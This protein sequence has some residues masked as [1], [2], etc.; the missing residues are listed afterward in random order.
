[1]LN[2]FID[3]IETSDEACLLAVLPENESMAVAITAAVTAMEALREHGN[4]G[5]C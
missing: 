3:P 4:V 5:V 1:M 2:D